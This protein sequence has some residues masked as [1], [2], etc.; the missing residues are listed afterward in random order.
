MTTTGIVMVVSWVGSDFTIIFISKCHGYKCKPIL[1]NRHFLWSCNCRT[2][3]PIVNL[4]WLPSIQITIMWQRGLC[5]GVHARV[6]FFSALLQL[7]MVAI[8]IVISLGLSGIGLWT[9]FKRGAYM[10][11]VLFIHAETCMKNLFLN[12]KAADTLATFGQLLWKLLLI[13]SM[14]ELFW[15]LKDLQSPTK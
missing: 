3:L 2:L 12:N 15:K 11:K 4:S 8:Q 6:R 7:W 9:F 10:N 5:D 1:S 13:H 14:N